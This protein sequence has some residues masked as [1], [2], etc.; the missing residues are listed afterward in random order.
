MTTLVAVMLVL[1]TLFCLGLG[2][3]VPKIVALL[4][5]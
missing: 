5:F 4:P 1:A 3:F 2:L